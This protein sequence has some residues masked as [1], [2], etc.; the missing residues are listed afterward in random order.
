MKKKIVLVAL[1]LLLTTSV[2]ASS[3]AAPPAAPEVYPAKT[4]QFVI[5][6]GAGGGTDI[7]VRA[8]SVSAP[9]YFGQPWHCVNRPGASATVGWKYMLEQPADGYTIILYSPAP[10]IAVL[11]EATPPF[12]P[13]DVKVTSFS[14]VIRVTLVTRVEDTHWNTWE[15]LLT[16]I[17]ANP[18]K[19]TIGQ[20]EAMILGAKFFFE[21]VGIAD[22]VIWVPYSSGADATADFLGKHLDVL[23]GTVAHCLPLIPDLAVPIVNTSGMA[24]PPEIEEFAGAPSAKDLGYEGL[25]MPRTVSVHPDTS[26]EIADFI[27]AAMGNLLKDKSVVKLFSKLG[28]EIAYVPRAEAEVEYGKMVEAVRKLIK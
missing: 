19:L 18:G 6:F 26:D 8:M 2:V 3:C 1:A 12:I 24:I 14:S 25:I 7:T 10:I 5:P 17:E 23:L 27:S 16:W 28:L 13:Y 22:K 9:D 21:Q 11:K 20:S 15:K 4:I